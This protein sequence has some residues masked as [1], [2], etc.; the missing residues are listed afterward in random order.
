ML[1]RL[2]AFLTRKRFTSDAAHEL[3]TPLTALKGRIG[4]TLSKRRQPPVYIETL[5]EMEEQVD[6]LIHLSNDLL[7]WLA[8]TRMKSAS[9]KHIDLNEM[10]EAVVDQVRPLL[11]PN[12]SS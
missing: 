2:Q 8:W 11:K 3:R 7:L 9:A 12:Q 10:I 4:V 5:Q 6:R 1:E